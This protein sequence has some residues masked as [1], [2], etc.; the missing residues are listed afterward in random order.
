MISFFSLKL[1]L[2][3]LI[4]LIGLSAI[5]LVIAMLVISGLA[6]RQLARD[7]EFRIESV[8]TLV[9]HSTIYA[10]KEK[11]N[12]VQLLA[13][14]QA[15]VEGIREAIRTG[16]S[17]AIQ[18]LVFDLHDLFNL[19]IF[20]VLDAHGG[21]LLRHGT[22]LDRVDG[23][24]HP[25]VQ[26]SLAGEHFRII[27]RFDGHPAIVASAPVRDGA[28]IIGH[29]VGVTLL[30]DHF[31]HEILGQHLQFMAT[32]Q[33]AFFDGERIIA[34]S[35]PFLRGLDTARVQSGEQDRVVVGDRPFSLSLE[36]LGI[37]AQSGMLLAVDGS[38][39]I[40]DQRTLHQILFFILAFVGV[41]ALVFG[42][43]LSRRIIQPLGQV[44]DNLKEIAEGDADLTRN[45][46]VL[47]RDEVGDLASSFNRFLE[48]MRGMV[49]RIR[50]ASRDLAGTTE[51]IRITSR[52][53]R[54][55][56]TKQSQA[57][58]ECHSGML[59]IQES[60]SGI[61]ASTGALVES[62]ELSSSATFELGAT[63]E[64]IAGQIEKLFA[65]VEEV[66]S[67]IA[68]MSVTS[69]QI[70]ENVE[71]LSHSTETTASSIL[72]LDASI[73]E[74]EENAERTSHLSEEAAADARK[75]KESVDETVAGIVAL[76]ETVDRATEVIQD[77]GSQSKSIG[78]ILT[79]I[80]EVADQ[81]SLLALNAAIIAAQAGEH[82]KGFAVVADEIRGLAERTAVST[83]EIAAI[84]ANLQNGTREA[85]DVMNAGSQRVHLEV[86]RSRTA[87]EALEKIRQSTLKAMEQVKGIVRATQEQSRGSRQITSSINQ[88]AQ[89]LEQ[90]S[91]A[92][93]QQTQGNRQLARAAEEMKEIAQQGKTST[94][95]QAKGSRQIHQGMDRIRDM[96]ERIDEATREQNRRSAQMV[97]ILKSLRS[98]AENSAR[99]TGELDKVVE[100][101]SQQTRTLENE[102]GAFKT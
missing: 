43:V 19:D 59:G 41:L 9:G 27:G 61:A 33:V 64:E 29:L 51:R 82:G 90:I 18:P 95:E 56:G 71:I 8:K 25:A 94:K 53:L 1:R 40:A 72:Q 16:S 13:R 26:A 35:A 42:I 17:Q 49:G 58:Q 4:P 54:E 73:K 87:G 22:R 5:P 12:Y 100:S 14:D 34:A 39:L 83:R 52:E 21:L 67:S 78:K 31:L 77:L 45:L 69:Q 3:I 86:A 68:E 2:K 96:I 88:V 79:V 70:A 50:E 80:D 10:E 38:D 47:S 89:M 7:L 20:E 92:V 97:E 91:S 99:R 23:R 93:N 15:F 44:V 46:P 48:R 30:N 37:D 24:S 55:E 6:E 81:T 63:T 75:G 76:R 84:I 36:S 85:V 32:L 62:A 28:E 102:V 11:A 98:I 66:T 74:I 60:I 101:V 65:V 57:L